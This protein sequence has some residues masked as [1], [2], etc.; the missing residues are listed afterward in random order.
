MRLSARSDS[1]GDVIGDVR[2]IPATARKHVR[3]ERILEDEA[4]KVEAR[5]GF[6]DAAIV[7]RLPVPVEYRELDP[8]EVGAEA[9]APDD[10]RHV[11]DAPIL[12]DGKTVLNAGHARQ[13]LDP[14]RQPGPSSFV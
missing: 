12:Q 2:G 9:G 4:E 6:H 1:R 3:A 14:L 13:T 11:D 8:A 7:A 5:L 10:V